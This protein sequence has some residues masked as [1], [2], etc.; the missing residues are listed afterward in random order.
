MRTATEATKRRIERLGAKPTK[1]AWLKL[2]IYDALNDKP[3]S[4]ARERRMCTA[5]T[6][7]YPTRPVVRRPWMGAEL[8]AEMDDAGVTDATVRWLVTR[9]IYEQELAGHAPALEVT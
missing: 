1:P 9:H 5:L 2:A 7:E 8:T 3:M 6:I 4:L